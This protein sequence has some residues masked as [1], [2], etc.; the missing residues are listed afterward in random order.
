MLMNLGIVSGGNIIATQCICSFK[1]CSPFDVCI[2]H[3]T[4]IGSPSGDIFLH[5]IIY[6]KIAKFIADI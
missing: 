3:H 4:W 5:K 2:A 1:Q 6:Y